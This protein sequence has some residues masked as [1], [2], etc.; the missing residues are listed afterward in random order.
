MKNEKYDIPVNLSIKTKKPP[1][2]QVVFEL[3]PDTN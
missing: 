1:E 3:N 2:S